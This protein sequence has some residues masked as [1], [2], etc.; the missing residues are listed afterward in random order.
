MMR[1]PVQVFNNL[2]SDTILGMDAIHLLGLAYL[3]IPDEFVFQTEVMKRYK[4]AAHL[5]GS[6]G[7]GDV[8]KDLTPTNNYNKLLG[9]HTQTINQSFNQ[10]IKCKLANLLISPVEDQTILA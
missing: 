10:S 5:C 9:T 7:C 1:W 6:S 2:S 8:V 4:K 3:S